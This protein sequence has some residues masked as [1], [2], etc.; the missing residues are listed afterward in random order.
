[1]CGDRGST[2][3]MRTFYDYFFFSL[4]SFHTRGAYEFIFFYDIFSEDR[5]GTSFFKGLVTSAGNLSASSSDTGNPLSAEKSA[6]VL[7]FNACGNAVTQEATGAT[8]QRP[9]VLET[10][11]SNRLT[12]AT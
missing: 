3:R 11:G 10:A 2:D 7:H 12:P 8:Y 9:L 4:F 6:F 1:M 5:Q